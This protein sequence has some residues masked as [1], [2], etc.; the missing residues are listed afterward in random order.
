VG[1]VCIVKRLLRG[2]PPPPI[3]TRLT[4]SEAIGLAR[5]AA[6]DHWLREALKVASPQQGASGAAIWIV[7]TGGTGS[8]LRF[9][10]DDANGDILDRNERNTR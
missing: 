6:G 5:R 1:L 2:S 9:V 3:P 4:E 8:S 7:E 10:I